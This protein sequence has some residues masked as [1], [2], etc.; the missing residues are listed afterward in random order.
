[1]L[2]NNH[3]RQHCEHNAPCHSLLRAPEI[4]DGL[5]AIG[6]F[7]R[8]PDWTFEIFFGDESSEHTY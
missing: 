5:Y 8:N 4:P 7:E 2:S 6:H 1:M 3:G